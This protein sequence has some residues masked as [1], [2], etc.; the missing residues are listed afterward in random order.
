MNEGHIK[1]FRKMLD[2]EWYNDNNTKILFLHCLL[3]ANW[4]EQKFQGIIIPRGSFITSLN[5]LAKETGLTIRQVRVS[6]EKLKMTNELTS[7]VTSKWQMI[8]I[9]KYNDYQDYDFKNDKQNDKQNDKPMTTIEE[10][11]EYKNKR[12]NNNILSST[13]DEPPHPT[14]YNF[15]LET[16]NSICKELPQVKTL[17]DNRKRTL[18]N[19]KQEDFKKI[20]ELVNESDFLSGRKGNWNATFDWIIKPSNQIKILEGNYQNKKDFFEIELEKERSK[21]E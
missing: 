1:I 10:Y 8:N 9:V 15:F 12:I 17:S 13:S 14:D 20:C 21:N 19:I 4:K 16:F 2:W 7:I 3:R 5:H 18:K 6:L 11:K